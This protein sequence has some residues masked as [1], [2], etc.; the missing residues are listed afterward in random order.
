[1]EIEYEVQL[2][3][4]ELIISVIKEVLR[5]QSIDPVLLRSDVQLLMLLIH[6]RPFRSP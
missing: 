3:N 5:F 6:C 2:T 1:M 4:L